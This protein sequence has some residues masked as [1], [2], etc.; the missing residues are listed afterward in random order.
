MKFL[1]HM[2]FGSVVDQQKDV[3]LFFRRDESRCCVTGSP[4]SSK[5]KDPLLIRNYHAM[6]I[7]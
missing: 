5:N 2:D 6:L 1:M 7:I 4:V 3:S